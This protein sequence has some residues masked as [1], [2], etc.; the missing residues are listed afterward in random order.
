MKYNGPAG[1]WPL[2]TES[3]DPFPEMADVF[4]SQI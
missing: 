1:L 2:G 4:T 3:G